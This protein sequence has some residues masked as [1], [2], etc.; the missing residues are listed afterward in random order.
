M[1]IRDSSGIDAKALFRAIVKRGLVLQ[2]S[3]GG[4]STISQQWAKQLFTEKV[5]SNTTVSYTHLQV[6]MGR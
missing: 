5:A 3:A 1:C 4:G 6:S 2:K